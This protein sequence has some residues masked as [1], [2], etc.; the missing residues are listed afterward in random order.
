MDILFSVALDSFAA[1]LVLVPAFLILHRHYFRDTKR[2]AAYCLFSI[3]LA[4][5]AV[6]VGIPNITYMHFQPNLNLIPFAGFLRDFR[7]NALNVVMFLPLGFILPILWRPYRA[8]GKTVVFAFC[9][10][11]VIELMQMF[12]FRATD[13]NDLITNTLG[14]YLGFLGGAWCVK[15]SRVLRDSICV[16]KTGNLHLVLCVVFAVMFLV[17]PF[18]SAVLW[19]LVQ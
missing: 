6:L 18:V 12:T 9:L 13:V 2:T 1:T 19:Q 11:L 10:S 7:S 5:V 4:V 16:A 8:A 3:Y 14:A 15:K 17:R